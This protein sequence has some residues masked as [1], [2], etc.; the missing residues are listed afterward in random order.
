LLQEI[1]QKARF[2]SGSR[3]VDA[4][5]GCWSFYEYGQVVVVSE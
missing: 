5:V 2:V 1:I 4:F 3:I